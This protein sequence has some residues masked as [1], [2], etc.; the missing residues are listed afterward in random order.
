MEVKACEKSNFIA[1][2]LLGASFDFQSV[3]ICAE[4]VIMV[5]REKQGA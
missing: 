2:S 3:N 5:L 4:A 1:I